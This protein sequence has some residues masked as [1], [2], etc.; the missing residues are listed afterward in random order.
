MPSPTPPIGAQTST[1]RHTMSLFNWQAP[2]TTTAAVQRCETYRLNPADLLRS[3]REKVAGNLQAIQTLRQLSDQQPLTPAQ[4]RDL[5]RYQG[6]G[7]CADVFLS[8][9]PAEWRAEAAQLSALL[10]PAEYAIARNS[11]NTAFYTPPR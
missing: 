10:T 3:R 5:A 4:Q 2:S 7:L 8:P 6:W 11:V 9:P 1:P